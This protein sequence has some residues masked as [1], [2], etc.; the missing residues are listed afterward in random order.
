[1]SRFHHEA[2][3]PLRYG[4]EARPLPTNVTMQRQHI[5]S[6]ARVLRKSLARISSSRYRCSDE[7]ALMG[8]RRHAALVRPHRLASWGMATH[9]RNAVA[10]AGR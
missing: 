3:R 1:M 4:A 9:S 2:L 5:R 7:A 10:T 8:G 6:K